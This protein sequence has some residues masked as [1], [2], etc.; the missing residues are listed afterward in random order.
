MF[1]LEPI[2]TVIPGNFCVFHLF[3]VLIQI[4]HV[5]YSKGLKEIWTGIENGLLHPLQ[6]LDFTS[7]LT[8]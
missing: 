8:L 6:L 3:A 5:K 7:H 1:D 4:K 2:Y